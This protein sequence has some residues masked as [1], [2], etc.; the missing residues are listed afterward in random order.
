MVARAVVA[1][2]GDSATVNST[3]WDS[4]EYDGLNLGPTTK[5]ALHEAKNASNYAR[6][7][8]TNSLN[9]AINLSLSGDFLHAIALGHSCAVSTMPATTGL[10]STYFTPD[11]RPWF[12]V[13]F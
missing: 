3:L 11:F 8:N 7:V 6:D 13:D 12:P 2:L 5:S 9:H 10:R 1:K 4:V